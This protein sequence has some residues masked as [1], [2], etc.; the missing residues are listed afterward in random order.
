MVVVMAPL[1]GG[2]TCTPR[3][4][5]LASIGGDNITS[6]ELDQSIRDRFKNSPMGFDNQHGAHGR[7]RH[8]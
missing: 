1:P 6:A 7:A 4:N 5:V 2:D 3:G 8:S